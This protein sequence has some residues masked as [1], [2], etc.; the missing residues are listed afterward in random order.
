MALSNCSFLKTTWMLVLGWEGQ[1]SKDRSS[2][3]SYQAIKVVWATYGGGLDEGSSSGGG[4]KWPD[5]R[6]NL[7]VELAR[8]VDRLGVWYES[9]LKMIPSF[10][11]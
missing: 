6:Y 8:T 4:K 2:D 9:E 11:V 5:P 3:T 1:E 10:E 7:K